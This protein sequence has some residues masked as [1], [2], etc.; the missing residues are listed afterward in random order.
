MSSEHCNIFKTNGSVNGYGFHNVGRG[1]VLRASDAGV[2][3][4]VDQ[5]YGLRCGHI[6]SLPGSIGVLH[7]NPDSRVKQHLAYISDVIGQPVEIL[8]LGQAQKLGKESLIVPYINTPDVKAQVNGGGAN[9]WGLPPQMVDRLK[10]KALSREDVLNGKLPNFSAPESTITTIDDFVPATKSLL[11]ETVKLYSMTDLLNSY[12][13]GIIVQASEC[14][15][16]YGNV[17]FNLE[18]N[19]VTM[20]PHGDLKLKEYH[21][22]WEDALESGK[23]HLRKSMNVGEDDKVVIS[24]LVDVEDTPGL[25]VLIMDDKTFSLGFNNQI[26]SKAGGSCI[27][28]GSYHP[29]T[30]YMQ[31][32]WQQLQELTERSF[33]IYLREVALAERIDFKTITGIVNIDVLVPGSLERELLKRRGKNPSTPYSTEFNPRW[34][35]WTDALAISARMINYPHSVAGLK[36]T[37]VH[38][39]VAIDKQPV[40]SSMLTDEIYE[41]VIAIDTQ[42]Q[43]SGSRVFLRMPDKPAGII[44]VGA[45]VRRLQDQIRN[46][47]E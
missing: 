47:L 14:D 41:K 2:Q 16:G 44:Y 28:T 32:N 27:G 8:N 42:A 13:L 45:N 43:K 25:S 26:I 20:T 46:A 10:R 17:V 39:V 15:G 33:E 7:P 23:N 22:S 12:P 9:V 30:R 36:Q 31:G 40:N 34:T 6:P 24:R 38:G 35:N 11:S 5:H 21:E 19:F 4:Y 37:I 3:D 29:K 18:S 1:G